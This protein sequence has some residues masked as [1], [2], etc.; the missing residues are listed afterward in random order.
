MME[1]HKTWMAAALNV[2]WR[3]AGSAMDVNANQY[4]VMGF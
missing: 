2:M 3:K 4:V 1:T